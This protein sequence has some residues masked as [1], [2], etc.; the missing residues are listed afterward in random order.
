MGVCVCMVGVGVG[1]GEWE[2]VGRGYRVGEKCG[3][4]NWSGVVGTYS[5]GRGFV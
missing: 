4:R 5:G 2:S 1:N 3:V